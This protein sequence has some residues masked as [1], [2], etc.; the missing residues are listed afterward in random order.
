MLS[1]KNRFLTIFSAYRSGSITIDRLSIEVH[2]SIV[3]YV[4]TK[5]ADFKLTEEQQR[6]FAVWL[7]D[8]AV[9]TPQPKWS[10]A[11]KFVLYIIHNTSGLFQAHRSLQKRRSKTGGGLA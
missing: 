11:K 1:W 9:T 5:F 3:A 7:C 4:A 8:L 2:K 10:V 6:S